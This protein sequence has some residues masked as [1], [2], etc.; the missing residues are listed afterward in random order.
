MRVGIIGCGLIGRRRAEVVRQRGTETLVVVADS[1]IARARDL[2]AGGQTE[3]VSD[4]ELVVRRSELDVVVVSTTNRWLAPITIAALDSGKHVLCEKPLGRN[5]QEAAQM[6]AAGDR[7]GRR[8]KTGFN[9]RH[10]P[11]I[12]RAHELIAEGAIGELMHARCRYGHGGRPGYD[13]EW[14]MNPEVSGG[15]ELLDQGVHAIDLCGWLLGDF[16]EAFGWTETGFWNNAVEENAFCLFR[17]ARN[18]VA[19]IHASWTQWKNIF[20]LEVFGKDG[21]VAVDGLGGSYGCERLTWGRRR[22]EGGAPIEE[23]FQFD[24][25]DLS[26]RAEWNEFMDAIRDDREPVGSG[27]DGWKAMRLIA[28]VYQ[29]SR[30]GTAVRLAEMGATAG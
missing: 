7:S 20:S 28:A 26:W 12:W 29:A 3:A 14:R 5:F 23:C 16:V 8:L 10:H 19:S 6:L 2:A 18:Q 27:R 11:A 13:K 15:G 21:Y 24:G 30:Q 1:D 25:P 22:P 4:W 9:H 17:T